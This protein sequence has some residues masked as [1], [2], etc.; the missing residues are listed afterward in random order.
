M[1][2]LRGLL[3]CGIAAV[4]VVVVAGMA[5]T[6]YAHASDQAHEA[7]HEQLRV[8]ARTLDGVV[9]IDS[10][11]LEFEASPRALPEYQTP[12]SGVYA[13]MFDAD[14]TAVIRSPSL[15]G[16]DLEPQGP[17]REG[18]FRFH[19]LQDGPDG[20]PCA[21]ATY[22]FLVS[23]DE[24][25]VEGQDG[26]P[27]WSPPAEEGRRFQVVVALDAT[28]RDAALAELRTFL[29]LLGAGALT[30]LLLG[31]AF[32][33]RTA[34]RP[35]RR[36][37]EEAAA[38]TPEDT[39]RRLEPDVVVRELASLAGTL[40]SALDRLGLALSRQRKFTSDASHELRTP[41]SVLLANV[42]LLLRRDR[43]PEEYR[44]GLVR[45]RRIA[46]SMTQITENLLTLARADDGRTELR[47]ERV[48]LADLVV[49]ACDD[50]QPLA[51]AAGLSLG[52]DVPDTDV[53]VLG[54][55]LYLGELLQNLLSNAM[56]FT[57]VGGSVRVHVARGD[58][59]AVLEVSDTGPGI[60]ECERER[61]FERFNR[62]ETTGTTGAG[63][64]LAIVRWIVDAH[65]G[66]IAV[67]SRVGGGSIFR[68]VLPAAAPRSPQALPV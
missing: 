41:L 10:D 44:D 4:G 36:M 19:E 63:L 33:A 43:S 1:R 60:P 24:E 5:L 9:E 59:G 67:E 42:D 20:L 50:F 34:L 62:L 28:P 11:G 8:R 37:T 32:V 3:L 2:S 53:A 18:E 14:G 39:S 61:I 58:A 49:D 6:V 68:V 31:G 26:E 45:Q 57:P 46:R 47:R 52:H 56:K 51:A 17:W 30:A 27:P 13:V 38:L 54:D 40:N 55:P 23:V 64:G 29:W 12:G 65:G 66:T 16:A 15:A 48:S 21:V 7:L 25:D 22:S 35:I